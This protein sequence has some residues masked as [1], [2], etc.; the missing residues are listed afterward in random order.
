VGGHDPLQDLHLGYVDHLNNI[1]NGVWILFYGERNHGFLKF[2]YI[3]V[4]PKISLT[5]ILSWKDDLGNEF[6]AYLVHI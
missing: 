6:N 1:N 3:N 5:S 4:S 2:Y